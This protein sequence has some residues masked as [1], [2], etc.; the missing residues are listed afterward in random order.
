M[1]E[2]ITIESL[3][4]ID[5]NGVMRAWEVFAEKK[6]RFTDIGLEIRRVHRAI[7]NA[8][9]GKAYEEYSDQFA[10]I[11]SQVE[12]IGDA[13][14]QI[15]DALKEVVYDS[16]YV[17]DDSLNQ[18]LLEAQHN[19]REGSS[20]ASGDGGG[21]YK[22]L[23]PKEVLYSTIKAAYKP[24]L[25]Y[26]QLP[27]RPVLVSTIAQAYQP[28]LSYRT[29]SPRP[30]LA[31][32]LP[33]ARI[34]D[35]TYRN[36]AQRA[37]LSSQIGDALQADISYAELALRE[38]LAST[39]GEPYM[40]DLS[41]VP[42]WLRGLDASALQQL[43]AFL[44][45]YSA[46]SPGLQQVK[47]TLMATQI[48]QI[49]ISSL[50]GGRSDAETASLIG[51]AV[52][53]NIHG[54]IDGGLRETLVQGIGNSVFSMM[55]GRAP[56]EQ[57]AE[58]SRI[59]WIDTD[60]EKTALGMVRDAAGLAAQPV[61]RVFGQEI[62]GAKTAAGASSVMTVKTG[63]GA[64]KSTA[65]IIAPRADTGAVS[66]QKVA[67]A[68]GGVA[69]AE[70]S[71]TLETV[72]CQAAA[73]KTGVFT[74]VSI[75]ATKQKVSGNVII[76]EAGTPAVAQET[77]SAVISGNL[78]ASAEGNINAVVTQWS[79]QAGQFDFSMLQYPVSSGESFSAVI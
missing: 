24:N 28:N 1:G 12:D 3:E 45:D 67:A 54:E 46:A 71:R 65:G 15:A 36:L 69:A 56:G 11:F 4:K 10:N 29:L 13:L 5:N 14:T 22:R 59:N 79:S 72:V 50:A 38:R 70:N 53:G 74:L 78:S 32:C 37:A 26:P 43:Q 63:T 6:Q 75:C 57:A 31:S 58:G 33:S 8:W 34:I 41:F 76:V 23:S 64:V 47:N 18:Q 73:Q 9:G 49:V 2:K 7:Q 27:A 66:A 16:F 68:L 61:S 44:L 42:I 17:A 40:P 21:D 77:V 20:D 62:S 55:Y 39:I 25:A 35:I 52:V 19:T 48:N 30:V 60:T 51:E